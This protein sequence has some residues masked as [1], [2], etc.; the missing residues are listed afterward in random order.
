MLTDERPDLFERL[1][2]LGDHLDAERHAAG[3][4]HA[5]SSAPPAAR[6]SRAPVVAAV[7]VTVL[8]LAVL[9]QIDQSD[10]PALLPS[11]STPAVSAASSATSPGSAMVTDVTT[12]G[13]TAGSVSSPD[14]ISWARAS[15][16]GSP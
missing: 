12:T 5:L 7:V 1:T 9:T 4:M 11:A 8:G 15:D 3:P 14:V 2:M 10:E 13:T 6:R 16:P